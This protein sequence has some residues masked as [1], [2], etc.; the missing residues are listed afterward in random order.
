LIDELRPIAPAYLSRLLELILN[1]LVSQSMK[2]DAAPIEGLLTTLA[3]DHE[4][5]RA[6]SEQI[7]S[8]FGNTKDGKWTMDILAIVKEIGHGILR[9]YRV[10][11]HFPWFLL[12][13]LTLNN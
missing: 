13:L 3:D 7:I 2:H 4:V 11:N 8:W 1:I 6:V 10:R 5:Q 12:C 9:N